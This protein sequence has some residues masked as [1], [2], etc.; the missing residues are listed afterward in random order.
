MSTFSVDP[1]KLKELLNY[2][3]AFAKQM[4]ED[5]ADHARCGKTATVA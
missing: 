2:C 5:F 1:N 3:I 4:V